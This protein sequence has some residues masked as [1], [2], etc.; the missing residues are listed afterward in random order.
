MYSFDSELLETRPGNKFISRLQLYIIFVSAFL[1]TTHK[2]IGGVYLE[3]SIA[4]NLAITL[5]FAH[6]R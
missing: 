4:I 5:C 3:I 1:L 6:V 2:T